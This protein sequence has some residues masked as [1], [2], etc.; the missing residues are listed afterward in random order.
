MGL[1]HKH[2]YMR[3]GKTE[4]RGILLSVVMVAGGPGKWSTRTYSGGR[5]L[6]STVDG[7]PLLV[8]SVKKLEDALIVSG[9]LFV[10]LHSRLIACQTNLTEDAWRQFACQTPPNVLSYSSLVC[11]ACRPPISNTTRLRYGPELQ[12]MVTSCASCCLFRLIAIGSC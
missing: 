2:F 10:V 12:L 11:L 4:R 7:K 9:I 3:E 1:T 8:S 6:G 5:N